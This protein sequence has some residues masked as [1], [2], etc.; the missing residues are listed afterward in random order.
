VKS[1]GALDRLVDGNPNLWGDL[2]AGSG[3]GA[4]SRDREF[5]RRFLMRRAD[6]LLF[7]SDY[8]RPGQEVPQ[9]ELLASLELPPESR[10]R[11]ER[12]NAMRLLGLK[13]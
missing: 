9:F 2:S 13:L 7:G 11:I 3:A 5:G 10:A 1:G 4:L 12:G 8:L 6:R